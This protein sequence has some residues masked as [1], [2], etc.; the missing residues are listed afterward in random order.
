MSLRLNAALSP[1]CTL[2]TKRPCSLANSRRDDRH[3]GVRGLPDEVHAPGT[4]QFD[5]ICFQIDRY[6]TSVFS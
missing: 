6:D 2:S 5:D 1:F 4:G 3:Y